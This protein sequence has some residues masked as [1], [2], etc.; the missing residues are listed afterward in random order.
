MCINNTIE[1]YL[2]FALSHLLASKAIIENKEKQERLNTEFRRLIQ[3][4]TIQEI[5]DR[6]ALR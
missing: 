4:I 6:T 5:F 2:T 3:G 1:S